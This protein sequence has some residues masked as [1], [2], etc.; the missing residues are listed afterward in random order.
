MYLIVSYYGSTPMSSQN[1][2]WDVLFLRIVDLALPPI[3]RYTLLVHLLELF[4]ALGAAQGFLLLLLIILRYRHPKTTPLALLLLVFS[5]RLGTVPSWNPGS[6]IAH[7][8]LFPAT[9]PLPFLFG[10]LLWW[11]VRELASGAGAGVPAAGRAGSVAGAAASGRPRLLSLHFL[12]YA[13]ETVAVTVT[14]LTLTDA[15]TPATQAVATTPSDALPAAAYVLFIEDIFAGS[16]PLWLP[17]RNALKVALNAVYVG[18]AWRIAFGPA[19][20]TPDTG[21][22]RW[23]RAL[24]L[25]SLGSLIPFAFV[26]V[27]PGATAG[28]ARGVTL[29]FVLLAVAMA[30]LIYTCTMLVLLTPGV[31]GC[32][33]RSRRVGRRTL[34][35]RM[36]T[37]EVTS[38]RTPGHRPSGTAVAVHGVTPHSTALRAEPDGDS[39]RLAAKV[40]RELEA[41]AFRDPDMS[42][43][44]LAAHLRVHPNR[45]SRAINHVYGESFPCVLSR[46]RIDYFIRRV[47]T[48]CHDSRNILELA[49]DAG[50][51][52]KST[53][54]RVFKE[55]LGIAPS[56]FVTANTDC[57]DGIPGLAIRPGRA[58]MWSNGNRTN[59]SV[60]RHADAPLAGDAPSYGGS[61]GRRR[62]AP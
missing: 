20:R 36:P 48:G 12:P 3:P 53:F 35:H 34:G 14:V 8:W 22:R 16:P 55:R 19:M 38:A 15:L 44:N 58:T 28:L 33:D 29:P 25:V 6:L 32:E 42:L 41:G 47:R 49:F 31:P 26:A 18:L 5:L 21:Q 62:T 10:P 4:A 50:F 40:R 57:G 52:S 59:R 45:L 51:Q 56:A 9:T 37:A 54:N 27:V 11:S 1:E 43:Q 46:C 30:L 60:Q 23:I 61:G 17:L 7:P 13:A 39:L 24:V 2:K